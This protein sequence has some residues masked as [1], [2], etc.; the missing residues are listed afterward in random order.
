MTCTRVLI[1]P[2]ILTVSYRIN[3]PLDN[4]L[5]IQTK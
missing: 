3:D 5:F 4:A 2:V 1:T